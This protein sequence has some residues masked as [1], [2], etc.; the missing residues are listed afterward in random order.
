MAAA[1]DGF[2]RL[3]VL[4]GGGLDVYAWILDESGFF[5]GQDSPT[6]SSIAEKESLFQIDIDGDG[7]FDQNGESSGP[8]DPVTPPMEDHE[9]HDH[10]DQAPGS[11]ATLEL[12]AA[13]T[14]VWVLVNP[15]TGL[16]YVQDEGSAPILITRSDSYWVGDVPLTR[17]D[18]TIMA[19][20]RDSLGRLRVLDGGGVDVYAWILD[21]SGFFIGEDSPTDSSIAAKEALFQMDIDGDGSFAQNGE[22]SSPTDPP[23]D[24]DTSPE[25]PPMEDHEEHDGGA[26]DHMPPPVTSG[27]Y[28]DITSWGTFHGSNHNSEDDELVGRPNGHH[29][30]GPRGL[31]Q[32][33]GVPRTLGR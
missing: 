14:D 26:H 28:L 9:G 1:R 24:E 7:F 31:Q 10:G 18:A 2:G 27:D 23:S 30:R 21:E 22:S 15:E 33:A 6:D 17:D 25:P 4:D 32:P 16:A 19:A 11:G 12:V 3:R 20:A 29:H 8:A 13:T 5:I